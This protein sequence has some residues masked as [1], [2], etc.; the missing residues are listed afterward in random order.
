MAQRGI[1][2]GG[3]FV[4]SFWD[5]CSSHVLI[6]SRL[7]AELILEGHRWKRDVY[8]PMKQ[9]VIWAGAITTRIW[10]DL[11]VVHQGRK[12]S[13]KDCQ[14]Y[15]WDM[16]RDV[17]LSCAFLDAY[18][19][20]NWRGHATD[21]EQLR[22]LVTSTTSWTKAEWGRVTHPNQTSLHDIEATRA[23]I[24]GQRGSEGLLQGA[25]QF[26]GVVATAAEPIKED[27]AH[28]PVAVGTRTNRHD[29]WTRE[30]AEALRDKLR[31]QMKTAIPELQRKLEAVAEEFPEAFGEDITEPCL[32]KAFKIRLKSGASY[33]AMVPRRL[34]APML[35]EV[36]KQVAALLAQ[37]VIRPS[38]SPW[39]FPLVLVRRPGSDKIRTCVD[40]R[41]LNSMTV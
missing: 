24:S 23:H 15:V 17:T 13:V 38:D 37:G 32:L 16:G 20:Q 19:L 22:Q 33:V 31:E 36:K 28:V 14:F 9:G 10:A 21:D 30:K 3:K 27:R 12:I 39:A 4:Q 29:S 18:H 5:T 11:T 35:E 25:G 34:S 2:V 26:N 41:L 8:L 6:S 7:A 1:G 40:F